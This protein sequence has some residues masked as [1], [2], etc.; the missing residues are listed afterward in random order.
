MKLDYKNMSFSYVYG[1]K[2]TK[3]EKR[4]L[5]LPTEDIADISWNILQDSH[6]K[7][8]K[9]KQMIMKTKQKY[10]KYRDNQM[11]KTTETSNILMKIWTR[12][13]HIS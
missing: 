8:D 3:K 2:T 7:S 12:W 4:V 5:I 6:K 11:K 10:S 1:L 13:T 9:E